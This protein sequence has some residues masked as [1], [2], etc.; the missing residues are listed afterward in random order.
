MGASGRPQQRQAVPVRN[1]TAARRPKREPPAGG[2][3]DA[4]PPPV[5]ASIEQAEVAHVN[6]AKQTLV[7]ERRQV[8]W[9]ALDLGRLNAE[10]RRGAVSASVDQAHRD[11]ALWLHFDHAGYRADAWSVSARRDRHSAAV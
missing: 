7:L 2:Q 9:Q 10:T 8:E 5:E 4:Q 6:V 1:K 11:L 3:P